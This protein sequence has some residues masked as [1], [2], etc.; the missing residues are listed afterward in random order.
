MHLFNLKTYFSVPEDPC[1]ALGG[2]MHVTEEAAEIASP[3]GLY[4]NYLP[5]S[6]CSWVITSPD[7]DKTVTFTFNTFA[8]ENAPGCMYDS[9]SFYNSET[10]DSESLIGK[11]L[12]KQFTCY[13]LYNFQAYRSYY[14]LLPSP[15]NDLKST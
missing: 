7:A 14:R 11:F 1:S 15:L 4:D 10:A 2:A 13:L 12:P 6:N 8:L 9:L 3:V 5:N